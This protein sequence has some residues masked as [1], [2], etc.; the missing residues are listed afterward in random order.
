[1]GM[2]EGL[3]HLLDTDQLFQILK[4]LGWRP[5]IDLSYQR[6]AGAGHNEDAWRERFGDVLRFLYPRTP[7]HVERID[8]DCEKP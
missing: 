5:G 7:D 2:E 1:M 6:I 3:R 8:L 4:N